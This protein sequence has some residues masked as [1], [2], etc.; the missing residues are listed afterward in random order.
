MQGNETLILQLFDRVTAFMKE[1]DLW[2]K[3][4]EE[5]SGKN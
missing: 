3:K 2:K 5:E 1:I 4:F